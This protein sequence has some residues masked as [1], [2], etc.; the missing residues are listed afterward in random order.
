M[1]G[2]EVSHVA[3]DLHTRI[4]PARAGTRGMPPREWRR[5]QDHPRACGDQRGSG[6][7]ALFSLG[8]SPRVRGPGRSSRALVVSCRIIPAR[9]G[10][11][12]TSPTTSRR[13]TDHPRACGDQYAIEIAVM[14]VD[15]SSPRV[16]GPGQAKNLEMY[17]ERIIPARA[18]TSPG[19]TAT[20]SPMS[21]HPRA[22][23]D[24]PKKMVAATNNT[25]SSPRVRGPAQQYRVRAL[26]P[27]IIPARAGTSKAPKAS[28]G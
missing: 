3:A 27:G 13:P 20:A 11:R 21:D 24:Q 25:G 18:G 16:R 5:S 23:G 9:A 22:C 8:S 19:V 2:P 7:R 15:G 1:R 10:T 26:R 12:A 14:L 4:I 17:N 28:L 6:A